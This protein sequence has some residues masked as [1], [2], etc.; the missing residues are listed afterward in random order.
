MGHSFLMLSAVEMLKGQA[1][2]FCKLT[3]YPEILENIW[4]SAKT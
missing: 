1:I 4:I 3:F 2:D